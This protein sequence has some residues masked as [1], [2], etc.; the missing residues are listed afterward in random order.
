[1]PEVTANDRQKAIVVQ[2]TK[3]YSDGK[4]KAALATF[5]K[6]NAMVQA[7]QLGLSLKE[8]PIPR[9][10]CKDFE[11]LSTSSTDRFAMYKLARKSCTCGSGLF[12]CDATGHLFALDGMIATYEKLS[13]P[14]KARQGA[15]L[16]ITIHPSAPEGYLRLAKALRLCD[17]EQSPDTMT[18][19]RWI[20]RQ[21]IDSVR[22]YGNKD[23]EKLKVL[24]SL[25]RMD[26]IT[27]LPPELRCMILGSLHYPD[28][29]RAMRVSKDWKEAC[30][31][32]S[33]WRHLRLVKYWPGVSS[34]P[35]RRHVFNDIICKRAQGK[36]KSLIVWK[37]ND[38]GIEM[39][40]LTAALRVLSG[41]EFLSLRGLEMRGV[42]AWSKVLFETAPLSLKALHVHFAGFGMSRDWQRYDWPLPSAIPAAQSLEELIISH[43]SDDIFVTKMLCST[44]W[45]KLRKL[46]VSHVDLRQIVSVTPSLTDLSIGHLTPCKGSHVALWKNL[47]RLE[48]TMSDPDESVVVLPQLPATLRSLEF[49]GEDG[50]TADLIES[51]HRLADASLEAHEPVHSP[52]LELE[53]LEHLRLMGNL[54]HR[55][56]PYSP[57]SLSWFLERIKPSMS[58]GTLT[59]LD[60][61][62]C[63]DNCNAFDKVLNKEAIRAL[64]CHDFIDQDHFSQCGNN[65][66]QWVEGFPN[67]TTLG[68]FPQKFEG[69]MMLVSQVLSRENMID[70][71]YTNILTGVWR[72]WILEKAEK[73]G[74][75][76]IDADRVPEPILKHL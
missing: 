15:V 25:L 50:S 46:R 69:C 70:T 6:A 52:V 24:A 72:D 27:S 4:F 47:E 49:S 3:L 21:A 11:A 8:I 26:I 17:T 76:I 40:I 9:C 30:L 29:C 35:L 20:Y 7:R 1:M 68:V 56:Y 54:Q 63:K 48:L 22:T 19:C 2:A 28:L 36:A 23:H 14:N 39:P 13:A 41:L 73:K 37:V 34:R 67:L 45:P 32:P 75:R 42:H 59:S 71:I 51:Y 43:V 38:F 58:N 57:D 62:F 16:L 65:F 66:I 44:T 64:S 74:V 18:R 5:K 61:T 33:L 60:T 10:H 53:R 55:H 31:D 12:H